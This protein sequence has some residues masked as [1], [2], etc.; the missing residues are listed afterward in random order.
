ML[1]LEKYLR[2]IHVALDFDY[3]DRADFY[4]II[5]F[6]KCPV[7]WR[8]IDGMFRLWAECDHSEAPPR[9]VI[10]GAK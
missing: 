8:L 6:G 2:K 10:E 1:F 3:S 9:H 4:F 5:E 7:V